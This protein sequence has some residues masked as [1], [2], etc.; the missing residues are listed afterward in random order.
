MAK[1]ER[2]EKRPARSRLFAEIFPR[3]YDFEDML[4]QQADRTVAGAAALVAWLEAD[5]RGDPAELVQI[6][7]DVDA[8]RTDLEEKLISSFSTPFDRQDIYSISR[9][10]D[11]ILNAAKETA[12]EMRA[13]GVA[14]D[15][16]IHD[17]ARALH[18]GA[19]SV[20]KAIRLLNSDNGH[21][22]AAIRQGRDAY[23]AI[24]NTYIAA[25]TD[26][27]RTSDAMAALKTRE[28][29]HHLRDGGRA[30]RTTLDIL[31]NALID[32]A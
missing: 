9:Q 10:M 11:Y 3:D 1:E 15:P 29:Y 26:L 20:A 7:A 25:M 27:F 17:M 2:P 24:E 23:H 32:I 16:P 19:S 13:F 21:A 8:M 30:L 28:I 14:P 18:T 5:P 31:H 22:E 12:I 6:E 4:A